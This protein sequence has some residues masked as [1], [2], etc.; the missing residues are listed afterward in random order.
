[1]IYNEPGI[2]D[3]I[4]QGDIFKRIPRVDFSSAQLPVIDEDNKVRSTTWQDALHEDSDGSG[5]T[6]VLP[7]VPVTAVV[8]TQNCDA[9]RGEYICLCQINDF[10]EAIGLETPPKNAKKWQSKIV[11]HTR[12]NSRL[13]YLPA[14]ESFGFSGPMAADFRVILRVKRTDIEA[15]MGLR[16]ARL[17]DV[18]TEHFRETLAQFFRRYPYNEWYSLT[19]EQ[20]EAYRES[21][22]EA[23]EAY[24]WQE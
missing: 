24:P 10:L 4:R 15:M 19:K 14:D 1:M 2:S 9:V 22:P 23:V 17:N 11:T 5:I 7:I 13:F 20:L 21:C 18:A 3:P 8:I 12:T 6:A 16:V